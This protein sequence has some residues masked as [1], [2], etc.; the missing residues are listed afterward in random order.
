MFNHRKRKTSVTAG[1]RRHDLD[2]SL[3]QKSPIKETFSVCLTIGNARQASLLDGEGTIWWAIKNVALESAWEAFQ[4]MTLHG[5][6]D[7]C[8][9]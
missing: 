9:S 7:R 1:R 2:R 8:L 5:D 4:Q 6:T 3:L